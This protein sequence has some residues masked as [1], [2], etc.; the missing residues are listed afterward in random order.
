MMIVAVFVVVMVMMMIV[1]VFL[2][3]KTTNAIRTIFTF[4]GGLRICEEENLSGSGT[5]C[6]ASCSHHHHHH[7]HHH[8]HHNHHHHHHHHYHYIA[9]PRFSAI[10]MCYDR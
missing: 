10:S 3:G 7:P 4:L 9:V 8:H 2:G 5:V 1:L 6:F